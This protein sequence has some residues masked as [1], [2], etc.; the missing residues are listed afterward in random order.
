[1]EDAA[2][3][4]LKDCCLQAGVDGSEYMPATSIQKRSHPWQGSKSLG[5][6]GNRIHDQLF[7]HQSSCCIQCV[8]E[9]D[10]RILNHVIFYLV[11]FR[12]HSHLLAKSYYLRLASLFWTTASIQLA[13]VFFPLPVPHQ[14]I[15]SE[16]D[17]IAAQENRYIL[18]C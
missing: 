3:L 5:V 12:C 15:F 14:T 11:E 13:F 8:D 7:T 1:M 4:L 16:T 6:L 9:D 17:A 10:E 18:L 2:L